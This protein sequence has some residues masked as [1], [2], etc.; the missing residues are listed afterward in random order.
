[1]A[2]FNTITLSSMLM[3][4]LL[5]Y[6]EQQELC[7]RVG[8]IATLY[9]GDLKNR[10]EAA[11]ADCRAPYFD[12]AALPPSSADS[13]LPASIGD[14]PQIN[15]SGPS[16]TK[17]ITN[18]L[19]SYIFEPPDPSVFQDVAPVSLISIVLF[20]SRETVLTYR[21][22]GQLVR[23]EEGSY[24]LEFN[25]LLEQLRHQQLSCDSHSSKPTE[26]L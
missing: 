17:P 20:A 11:A 6:I 19:F 8:F 26:A 24:K 18:P 5:T 25:S 7:N 21:A 10:F 22:V 2:Q 12:W 14:S 1:M 4:S 9:S 16:G 3:M 13:M 23:D 15:V